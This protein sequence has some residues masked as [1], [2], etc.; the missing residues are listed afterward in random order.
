ME[1]N[2]IKNERL[3]EVIG[4]K[5]KELSSEEIDRIIDRYTRSEVD[6]L[7][8]ND[9]TAFIKVEEL[10]EVLQGVSISVEQKNRIHSIHR[11]LHSSAN[12]KTII[13]TIVDHKHS[14]Y[15]KEINGYQT[16]YGISD[17]KNYFEFTYFNQQT[18]N[19]I[20]LDK[21]QTNIKKNIPIGILDKIGKDE[22]LVVGPGRVID[23]I[24]NQVIIFAVKKNFNLYK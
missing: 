22:F 21:L 4:F 10:F 17:D 9:K 16:G 18:N 23:I 24:D 20:I 14:N 2:I 8:E 1:K 19:S 15:E 13:Y 12:E 3:L 5:Q 11:G 6:L 7:G